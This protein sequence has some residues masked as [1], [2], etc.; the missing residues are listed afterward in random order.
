MDSRSKIKFGVLGCSRV[1]QKGMLPAICDSNFAELAMVGSRTT[2]KAREFAEQFHCDARGT[3]DEVINNKDIHAVYISLPNSL[4]EEWA[5]KAAERGKHVICEKPAALSYA[6][7]KKMAAV[8]GKNNTRLMEGLMFRYH[9]QHA[10]VRELITGGVLGE[11]LRFEGCFGYAMPDKASAMMNKK[12][13][14]GS[15]HASATYPVYASRMIFGEEPESVLC[16]LK[17]DPASGVDVRTDMVLRYSNGKFA[18]ISSMFGSYFQST[19]SVLGSQA[20]IRMGRAYA[21]PR[22]MGTK[23]FLDA[24]DQVQEIVMEPADQFRLMLDDFCQEIFL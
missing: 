17:I 13:G 4:H 10:K 12:L 21:V 11:L 7:A 6:S 18:F 1:A 23:I 16:N 20:N 2:E 15:F 5:I 3:Y 14:G 19:Y 8:C 22:E 9:P 24:D